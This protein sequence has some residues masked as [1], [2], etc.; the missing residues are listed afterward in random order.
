MPCDEVPKVYRVN[1]IK[2]L[3]KDTASFEGQLPKLRYYHHIKKVEP[4]EVNNN[5]ILSIKTQPITAST[6]KN[7]SNG[8]MKI[9]GKRRT[10]EEDVKILYF[11]PA[12]LVLMDVDADVFHSLFRF[13]QREETAHGD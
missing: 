9:T 2:R 7:G 4:Q 13:P 11:P 3:R 8:Q 1:H 12:M 10:S 6:K 5:N